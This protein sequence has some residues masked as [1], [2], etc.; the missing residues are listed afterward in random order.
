MNQRKAGVIL[1]YSSEAVKILSG[2][3]YTPIMLRLLGQSEYGLYQLVASVVSY[4]SLLSMGFASSY[5]RF[6]SRRKAENDHEG[7]AKLNGMFMCIFLV[8]SL[9][10][11]LCGAIMIANVTTIFGDGLTENEYMTARTLMILMIISL[12]ITFPNSVFDCN[13]IAHEEFIFQKTL[14]LGQ[15]VLNPFLSLPLLLL[16]KGSVGMV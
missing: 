2:L 7:I 15:S 11:L 3:I 14:S 12:A 9:I 13:L 5:M 16:G 4:L 1:T 10:C 6:Y 8:I